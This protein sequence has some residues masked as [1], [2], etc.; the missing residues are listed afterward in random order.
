MKDESGI[1]TIGFDACIGCGSCIKACPYDVR[2]LLDDG[3]EFY[4]DRAV[5]EIQM[6]EVSVLPQDYRQEA[7]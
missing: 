2:T 1:V 7:D 5:G 6:R 4:L 3:Q